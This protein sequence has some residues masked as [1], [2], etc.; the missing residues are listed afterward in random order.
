MS[1]LFF[2]VKSDPLVGTGRSCIGQGNEY[3]LVI[4]STMTRC[5]ESAETKI[6]HA[7][8]VGFFVV[9]FPRLKGRWKSGQEESRMERWRKWASG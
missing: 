4:L 6:V 9:A 3:R 7:E 8:G 5:A 1:W 2:K